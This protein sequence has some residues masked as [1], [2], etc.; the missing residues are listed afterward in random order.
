MC[1]CARCPAPKTEALSQLLVRSMSFTL[2]DAAPG[3]PAGEPLGVRLAAAAPAHLQRSS[4]G[5]GLSTPRASAPLSPLGSLSELHPLAMM[6]TAAAPAEA[7]VPVAAPAFAAP[8]PHPAAALAVP[9]VG[10]FAPPASLFAAL[11]PPLVAVVPPAPAPPR[12]AAPV[13]APVPVSAA[14]AHAHGT[15]RSAAAARAVAAHVSTAGRASSGA[16]TTTSNSSLGGPQAPLSDVTGAFSVSASTSRTGFIFD[17]RMT[18]HSPPPG[19]KHFEQPGRLRAIFARLHREG[20]LASCRVLAPRTAEDA[21]LLACHTA[22]HVASVDAAVDKASA[23]TD[24]ADMYASEGTPLAARL[25]AG[26]V[27]EAVQCVPR[28]ACSAFSAFCV[29]A[30]AA[31]V[32]AGV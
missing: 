4:G 14:A 20:V 25:A 22:A 3:S 8:L 31:C 17:E 28:S 12:A 7:V 16:T 5:L 23:R 10:P 9:P 24:D 2:Q 13:A 26:C 32:C 1:L 18:H 29:A 6:H 27:T 21:E 30:D 11:A 19:T 15:R